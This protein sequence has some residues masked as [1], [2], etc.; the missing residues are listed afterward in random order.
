GLLDLN[1]T[2]GTI[3]NGVAP[4]FGTASG[5]LGSSLLVQYLPAPTHLVYLLLFAVFILQG[6]GVALMRESSPPKPGALASLR[7]QL[8]IPAAARRPLALAAPA[9]VAVWAL[10]GFYLSLGP[11]LARLVVG[12]HSVVLGGLAVFAL[13]GS[14]GVTVL[15]IR[16]TPP[17]VVMFLATVA[18]IL[19][20]GLTLL[21]IAQ[22]SAAL[23]FIG[24]AVAGVGFGGGFQGALRT[25]LPLAAPHE[26]AGL[27]SSVYVLCYLAMG[28]PAVIAGFL[29]VHSGVLTTAREY[30]V[31]VI[32][33][34]AVALLG[35][36]WPRREQPAP[37]LVAPMQTEAELLAGS[38]CKA[39]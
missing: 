21:A 18:L 10:A 38:S 24:T 4:I 29:V 25:V 15:L 22:T 27:L 8:G 31:A 34:T 6:I 36:A 3:A 2:K 26:R 5:A 30:G 16:T 35:L 23:F 14:G 19:G 7:P 17:R 1:K 32:V 37:R 13:A 9:V 39:S 20:V 28:L 11:A 12:S 33:L